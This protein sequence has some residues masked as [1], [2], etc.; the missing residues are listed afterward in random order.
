MTQDFNI[1]DRVRVLDR[2]LGSE[3]AGSVGIVVAIE[4]RGTASPVRTL[5]YEVEFSGKVRRRFVGFQLKH[6]GSSGHLNH[7][8]YSC[9]LLLFVL[10]SPL[11]V[12]SQGL[13]GTA[14]TDK[15]FTVFVDVD[16]VLFNVTVFDDKN[17]LIT[18]LTSQNFRVY[19][20]NREQEIRSFQ[21]DDV[22]ATVG[23][24]I[25]NSGSMASKR[26]DVISA[27]LD[28]VS[29]IDR[30][31]E[32][33]VVNFNDEVSMPRFGD[34][35]PFTANYD[36]LSGALRS[37]RAAGRTA[38]YDAIA[39]ALRRLEEGSNARKALVILSDG[40]DNAS[41]ADLHEI[42]LMARQ[43]AATLF[44][45]GFYDASD[46]DRNPRVLRQLSELTG[47]ESYVPRNARE[48]HTIW[49][50]IGDRI[51]SQYTLG[52][53]SSNTNRDGLYRNV[54]IAV[55]D[56]N[57]KPLKVRTRAGYVASKRAPQ[58]QP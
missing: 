34:D 1:G 7:I 9:F 6:A 45:I 55:V 40:G 41:G 5:E 51:R 52:Y 37:T 32:I 33:F 25:D 56:K 2:V 48:L 11:A 13:P 12:L 15:P 49:L 18:G 50:R 47:G 22:P 20:D 39:V 38:L 54:T 57:R 21:A 42:V 35:M 58:V 27:A 8:R 44:T 31:D 10:T 4:A 43:S 23:L 46:K 24:V 53:V 29:S 17:R 14:P 19:E 26:S 30:R 3:F 36:E 16:L 28:F